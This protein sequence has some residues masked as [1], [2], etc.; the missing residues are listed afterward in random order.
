MKSIQYK[1]KSKLVYTPVDSVDRRSNLSYEEFVQEYAS[2]GKPLIITD[3]VTNWKASTKWNL[4][5]F[6]SNYGSVKL[7]RMQTYD[8]EGE[9][10]RYER[11]YE[12]M[13]VKDYIDDYMSAG[14]RNKLLYLRDLSVHDY[15][16]LWDDCE[17]SIYFNNWYTKLPKELLKKYSF[18]TNAVLIGFKGT[19]IGLHYDTEFSATWVSLISGQKKVILFAPDQ[20]K[21]LYEGRVNCFKPNLEKFPLYTKAKP[22]ECILNQ[23]E[24]LAYRRCG[25]IK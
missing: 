1:E 3:I 2:V 13:S 21:Y 6:R 9:A 12:T 8:P 16:E 17:E 15:P 24:T 7:S 10:K 22:V 4:D 18:G 23:G 20:E 5:F 19:S 14:A 11:T 25:G